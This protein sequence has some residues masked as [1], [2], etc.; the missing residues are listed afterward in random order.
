M[1]DVEKAR[2]AKDEIS[3]EAEVPSVHEVEAAIEMVKEIIAKLPIFA[4][5]LGEVVKDLET[6][7]LPEAIEARNAALR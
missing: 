5:Y 4:D 3:Y 7:W 6:E 2:A 1:S